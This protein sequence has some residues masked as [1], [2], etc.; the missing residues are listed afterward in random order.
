MQVCANTVAGQEHIFLHPHILMEAQK[1]YHRSGSP[2]TEP[3]C[4]ICAITPCIPHWPW[5][6]RMSRV[7]PGNRWI[8]VEAVPQERDQ[9]DRAFGLLIPG[10]GEWG[11]IRWSQSTGTAGDWDKEDRKCRFSQ[12]VKD[13]EHGAQG[14]RVHFLQGFL[15]FP[16]LFTFP[17]HSRLS[18]L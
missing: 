7:R 9:Q 16:A 1:S 15:Q 17:S 3:H 2:R 18:S 6:A 10:L 12:M 13:L 14:L 8:W 5:T 4:T 11:P